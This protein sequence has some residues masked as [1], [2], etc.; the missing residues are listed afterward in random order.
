MTLTRIIFRYAI[1]NCCNLLLL[2]HNEDMNEL[3]QNI[4]VLANQENKTPIQIIAQLQAGAVITGNDELL[5]ALCEIKWDYIA[6]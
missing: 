4:E 6:I 2:A 1:N 3:R 5:D